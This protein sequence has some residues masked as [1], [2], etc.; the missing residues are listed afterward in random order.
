MK[1]MTAAFL[2]LAL[3][4]SMGAVLSSCGK[5]SPDGKITDTSAIAEGIDGG[6]TKPASPAVTEDLKKVFDK[7]CETLAGTEYIPVAYLGSQVVAGTNHSFLCRA[8]ASYGD[9]EA[10]YAVVTVYEDLEGNAE[11]LN[12]VMTDIVADSGDAPGAWTE[13]GTPEL[14]DEAKDALAKA[15]ETLTGMEYTPVALLATQTV[16]GT[17][18]RILCEAAASVPG[19]I[20]GYA[21][22]IVNRD[23]QGGAEIVETLPFEKEE[24]TKIANPV[25]EYGSDEES[26]ES[27]EKHVGFR[28]DFPADIRADQYI[29]I[30]GKILEVDFEAG[31]IRKA[32]GSDDISGDWNEYAETAEKDIGGKTVTLKGNGGRIYLAI[33]TDGGYTY[34][35]GMLDG[36]T[37]DRMASVVEAVK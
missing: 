10:Y 31:Y 34:C 19:D 16:S 37:E 32:A 35:V 36:V 12:E 17:N 33:W 13:T 18:Y 9:A 30:S 27:A 8:R 23:P 21:I 20:S 1:R 2:I 28:L 14:T 29:V 5:D 7:A 11:I 26:L 6:W 4:A 25:E 3:F 22:L 24:Y 15:C